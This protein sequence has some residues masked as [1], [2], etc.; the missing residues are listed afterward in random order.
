[1][2]AWAEPPFVP[3]PDIAHRK[4]NYWMMSQRAATIS[5]HVF[6]AGFSLAVYALFYVISDLWGWQLGLFR[7]L[8][9]NALVAYILHGMVDNTVTAFMPKDSPA[10][11]VILGFLI[12]FY[13]TYLML[14]FLEKNKIFLKL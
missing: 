6:A 14:R 7:T 3:P 13:I 10:W 12:Y 9:T 8:G 5:Y 11:Y 4:N 2:L 1:A